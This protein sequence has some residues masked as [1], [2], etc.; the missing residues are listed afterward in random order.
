[1]YGGFRKPAELRSILSYA[2]TPEPASITSWPSHEDGHD[3]CSKYVPRNAL[4]ALLHCGAAL[5]ILP[6]GQHVLGLLSGWL[7]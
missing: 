3:V 4:A 1:L 6:Q 2:A 7:G 5:L